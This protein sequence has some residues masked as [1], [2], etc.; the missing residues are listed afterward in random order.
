MFTPI[1]MRAFAEEFAKI[2]AQETVVR[3]A[4]LAAPA[5]GSLAGKIAPYALAALGGAG[6]LH[7]G[8][9]AKRRY[10]IGKMVEEQQEA[11]AG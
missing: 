3:L 2:A 7:A 1:V 11:R 6:V 4:K 10:D 5:A 9:K 8:K